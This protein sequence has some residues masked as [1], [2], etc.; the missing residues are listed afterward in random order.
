MNGHCVRDA[1]SVSTRVPIDLNRA[2]VHDLNNLLHVV[3]LEVQRAALAG[4]AIG[5]TLTPLV[6]ETALVARRL[7]Y[8]G[9]GRTE[10][11][12]RLTI[13]SLEPALR[14]ALRGVAL[15]TNCDV[16]DDVVAAGPDELRSVIRNLV[17]NARR[18]DATQIS[19][20]TLELSGPVRAI[21]GSVRDGSFIALEVRDNG[22]GMTDTVEKHAFTPD[23]T[24][25]AEGAGMGLAWV[26]DVVSRAGGFVALQ[27]A[28]AA[29]TQLTL[30]FPRS[31][32]QDV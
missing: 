18:A 21:D 9:M 30:A 2:L 27:T 15:E 25:H 5:T 7:L 22:H 11:S 26:V 23:F 4:D 32:R 24:T 13:E 20:V 29:G 10:A 17:D 3:V 16:N 28:P 8:Q 6:A 1:E 12:I 19:L 14:A 31:P